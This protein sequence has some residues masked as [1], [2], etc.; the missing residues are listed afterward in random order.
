[1]KILYH[2]RKELNPKPDFECEYVPNLDELV[3]RS[4]V[5]ALSLPVSLSTYSPKTG[6]MTNIS[7]SHLGSL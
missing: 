5:I 7:R 4:D 1:M 3:K 6:M 2:N